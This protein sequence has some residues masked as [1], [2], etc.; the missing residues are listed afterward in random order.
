MSGVVT[1]AY[2][3]CGDAGEEVV[4]NSGLGLGQGMGKGKMGRKS[5]TKTQIIN[6][7]WKN[8]E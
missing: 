5:F 1:E 2:P 8:E 3:W 7:V 4:V 6:K